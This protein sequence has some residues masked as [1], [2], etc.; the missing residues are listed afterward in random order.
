MDETAD[1]FTHEYIVIGCGATGFGVVK[2]LVKKGKKVLAI[3]ISK[4]R[5]EILRDENYDAIVGDAT[6]ESLYENIDFSKVSI[7]MV[8][9]SDTETNRI[10]VEIIRKFSKDVF[11]IARSQNQKSKEELE[12]AGADFVLVPSE[13]MKSV[14]L[15]VIKK[16]DTYRKLRLLGKVIESC[17]KKLGIFTH[18]NP[19]PDAISSAFALKE[20]A[21]HYGVEA[22]ILYFGEIMHQENRSMVNLL[23]IPLLK[24]N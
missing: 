18:D 20:I 7:I 12:Q 17:N 13:A 4:E 22:D 14:V 11:I 1:K 5:V 8:L 23:E 2:D 24:A 15:D 16:A 9:T 10:A 6:D 21:K 19:D 3:D